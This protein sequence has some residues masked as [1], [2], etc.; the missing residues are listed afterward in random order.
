MK[1]TFFSVLLLSLAA[2]SSNTSDSD[3]NVLVN[4]DFESIDGWL[5]ADQ[6]ATLTREKAH[7]GKCAIKVDGGHEYSI[8]FSKLLGQLHDSK[9]KELEVKAWA[10]VPNDK[11]AASLVIAMDDPTAGPGAKPL[12]WEGINLKEEAKPYGKWQEITKVFKVPANA[13]PTNKLGIYLWRNSGDQA[14]YVDDI[15][16]TAVN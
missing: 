12:M 3:P 16:I 7:S 4:S 9:P 10:F 14:V 2:C 8:G 6:S 13:G 11:A 5:P 1:K 15:K